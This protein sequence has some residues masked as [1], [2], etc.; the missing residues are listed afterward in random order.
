MSETVLVDDGSDWGWTDMV[1][2]VF[3][4]DET[5]RTVI[6]LLA[7]NCVKVAVANEHMRRFVAPYNCLNIRCQVR[8]HGGCTS[9]QVETHFS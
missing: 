1:Y 5:E 4:G 6:S 7:V 8:G 3:W 2:T 9:P